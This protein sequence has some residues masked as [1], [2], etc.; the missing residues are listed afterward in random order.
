M[1]T[2]TVVLLVVGVTAVVAA[3][4]GG[5]VFLAIQLH[6]REAATEKADRRAEFERKCL[7]HEP[8]DNPGYQSHCAV[9]CDLGSAVACFRE[10]DDQAET[11]SFGELSGH[12]TIFGFENARK[13]VRK[14]CNASG[15]NESACKELQ[16]FNTKHPQRAGTF[17][18]P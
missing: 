1:K 6:D 11:A 17:A 13:Y 2:Q 18:T 16:D 4:V 9:A 10:G 12:R 5:T 14:G 3:L 8:G 15:Q 7:N